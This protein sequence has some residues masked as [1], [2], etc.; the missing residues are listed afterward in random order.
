MNTLF[1]TAGGMKWASSRMRAY[2]VVP[3]MD[4]AVANPHE[5][6]FEYGLTGDTVHDAIIFQKLYD[7][8]AAAELRAAGKQVWWDIC[9]PVWWWQPA[10]VRGILANCDGVVCSTDELCQDL[11]EWAREQG[12]KHCPPIHMIPDRLELSA[13]PIQHDY[14]KQSQVTRFIWYGMAANRIGLYGAIDNLHRLRANGHNIS[15]TIFDDRPDVTLDLGHIP[16][17]HIGWSLENENR[18]IA[19]HDIALLPPYPGPWGRV[20]SNNRM[21]T[22]WACGIPD[23][24]GEDYR[25]VVATI[26]SLRIRGGVD[27]FPDNA[28]V[29]HSARQWQ[30]LLSQ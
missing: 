20:K 16:V 8:V 10:D 23:V 7:Q 1:V 19:E 2:W 28:K 6:V 17:Y 5:K 15:L 18:V 12:V 30:E 29:I 3:Y 24:N 14:S 4:N 27:R 25:D 26:R 9:D 13:F 22:A 21:L 11:T